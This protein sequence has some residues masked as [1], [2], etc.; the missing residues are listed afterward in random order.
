MKDIS[1]KYIIKPKHNITVFKTAFTKNHSLKSEI[2]CK[3]KQ[4][5]KS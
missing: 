3:N 4:D 2:T 1:E 5:Q